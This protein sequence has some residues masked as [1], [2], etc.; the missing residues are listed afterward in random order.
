LKLRATS[1]VTWHVDGKRVGS[2]WPL[3]AGQHTIAA[4]DRR[5]HRDEV[6]IYVK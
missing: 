6:T 4:V 1:S 3:T 5:G 2:E